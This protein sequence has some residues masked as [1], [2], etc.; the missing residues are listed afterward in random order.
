[1]SC[2]ERLAACLTGFR[3][4][5]SFWRATDTLLPK[6]DQL[7]LL[8]DFGQYGMRLGGVA[9]R[10]LR[11]VEVLEALA[12]SFNSRLRFGAARSS[13][14]FFSTALPVDSDLMRITGSSSEPTRVTVPPDLVLM[15]ARLPPEPVTTPK[16]RLPWY[17]QLTRVPFF[18]FS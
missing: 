3:L 11:Y 14:F 16:V 9:W 1:M 7:D 17:I 18:I 8:A 10:A 15:L 13:D 2:F 6:S 12:R 5:F 4:A